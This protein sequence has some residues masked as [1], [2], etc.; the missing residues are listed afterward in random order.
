MQRLTLFVLDHGAVEPKT[1]TYRVYNKGLTL[2]PNDLQI[3]EGGTPLRDPDHKNKMI[4]RAT[5]ALNLF[6]SL[7]ESQHLVPCLSTAKPI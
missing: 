6:V 1:G 3:D 7:Y 4:V 5:E 2:N